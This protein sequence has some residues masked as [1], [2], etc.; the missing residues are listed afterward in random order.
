MHLTLQIKKKFEKRE[1]PLNHVH[2]DPGRC[3]N[4]L[5]SFEPTQNY[6]NC[7]PVSMHFHNMNSN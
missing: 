1:T 5:L 7:K 6:A 4:F 3:F 2:N